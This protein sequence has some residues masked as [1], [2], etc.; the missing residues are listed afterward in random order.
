MQTVKKLH[1]TLKK[2]ACG[3]TGTKEQLYKHLKSQK[4]FYNLV[5]N[6]KK[7][8]VLHG[9]VPLNEENVCET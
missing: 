8:Y 5:G 3:Y 9:E 2:C 1:P 4:E 7:F 6:V